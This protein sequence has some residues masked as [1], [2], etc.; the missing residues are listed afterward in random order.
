MSLVDYFVNR[1]G[2]LH[3]VR[4]E[5]LIN[6]AAMRPNLSTP[7]I[8]FWSM[9]VSYKKTTGGQMLTS[10][11]DTFER[12]SASVSWSWKSQIYTVSTQKFLHSFL[13]LLWPLVTCVLNNRGDLARRWTAIYL[14]ILNTA[15]E[16]KDHARFPGIVNKP[17]VLPQV[18]PPL[19]PPLSFLNLWLVQTEEY[20]Y[21]WYIKNQQPRIEVQFPILGLAPV[22]LPDPSEISTYDKVRVP[23]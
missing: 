18:R 14:Y 8:I 2:D 15:S 9:H 17:P 1:E 23:V 5:G 13:G 7:H 3:S 12:S 10:L 4:R 21:W 16:F 6:F 11:W 22:T 19:A 20:A